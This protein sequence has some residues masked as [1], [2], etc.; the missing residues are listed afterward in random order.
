MGVLDTAVAT[1]ILEDTTLE[2]G[3]LTL[4]PRLNLKPNLDIMDMDTDME[5]MAD[6][7]VTVEVTVM[8]TDTVTMVRSFQKNLVYSCWLKETKNV[9]TISTVFTKLNKVIC[10]TM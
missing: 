8:V 2:K 6:M 7:A 9:H 5:V 1:L 10:F 3:R 4:N